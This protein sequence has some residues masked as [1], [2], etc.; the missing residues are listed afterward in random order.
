MDSRKDATAEQCLEQLFGQMRRDEMAQA[1]AFPDESALSQRGALTTARPG[2]RTAPKVAAAI[3]LLAA[4]SLLLS[5]EPAPQD[6]AQL[7]A[8]IMSANTLTTDTLLSVSPGTLPG[9]AELPEVFDT[10]AITGES[11]GIH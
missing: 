8:A 2:S 6:P 7:Y 1:P 11:Q 5:R 10:E 9:M 3:A 4:L